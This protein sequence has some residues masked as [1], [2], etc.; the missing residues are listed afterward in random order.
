MYIDRSPLTTATHE[1]NTTRTHKKY[2]SRALG[3]FR[4]TEVSLHTVTIDENETANNISIDRATPVPTAIQQPDA[5][6]GDQI[7]PCMDDTTSIELS[8][9][10]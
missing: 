1:R 7:S 2:I 4:I 6:T 5:V 9:D 8:K 3:L 10:E